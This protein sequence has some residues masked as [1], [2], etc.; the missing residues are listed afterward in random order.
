MIEKNDAVLYADETVC[1]AAV[2]ASILPSAPRK[3]AAGGYVLISDKMSFDEALRLITLTEHELSAHSSIPRPLMPSTSAT[4]TGV[5]AST[6]DHAVAVGKPAVASATATFANVNVV[7]AMPEK[8]A[9]N[10]KKKVEVRPQ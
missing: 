10:S 1:T 2:N 3:A 7:Y 4:A 6:S 5:G 9:Q 8:P